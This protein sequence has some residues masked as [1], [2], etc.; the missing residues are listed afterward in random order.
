MLFN[1]KEDPHEQRNVKALH[2]EVC[3]QGA[4]LILDWQEEQM[5]KSPSPVDPM[6]TVL[7]EGG[8]YHTRGHLQEYAQRLEQTGRAQG[9][10][11]LRRR[12]PNEP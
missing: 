6:Y 8:P 7:H 3:A 12:H 2:P 4:K 11:E 10:Q 1:V 9:A 5:L